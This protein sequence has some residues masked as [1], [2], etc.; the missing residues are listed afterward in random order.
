MAAL[1]LTRSQRP[2]QGVVPFVARRHMRQVADLV[3]LVFG[4]ELDAGGRSALRELQ[5]AAWFSP[6]LGDLLSLLLFDDFIAGFVWIEDGRVV[7]NV[8]YQRG[9]AYGDR[10]RISNVAVA[11]A[12]RG[13]GIAR[14]LMLSTLK[15]I[16]DQGGAWAVLSVRADNAIA[17]R[18]YESL[19][20]RAVCQDG[21]WRLSAPPRRPPPL[22]PGVPLQPLP[23]LAWDVR[24]ELA[25]ACRSQLAHWAEPVRPAAYRVSLNGWLTEML[26]RASGLYHVERW[27]VWDGELL[28]GAVEVF[29][30]RALATYRIR[31]AVRPDA[32]GSLETALIARALHFLAAAPPAPVLVEHDGDHVEGVAALEAAG[33]RAERILVTMRRAL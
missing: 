24:L 2:S 17:R 12:Y 33:F 21:V 14:A 8:T 31:F 3:S 18:L 30:G 10:W 6:L 13:R 22:D 15:A 28:A 29:A 23:P 19:G 20:F 5:W 27:G 4:D 1:T 9:D 26:G 7:G 16:A 32:R 25:Q 11:P